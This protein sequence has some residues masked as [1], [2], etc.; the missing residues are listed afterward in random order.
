MT[1]VW[2][3]SNR[4]VLLLALVP[5]AMLGLVAIAAMNLGLGPVVGTAAWILLAVSVL[6]GVGLI[7]QVF[8]PRVAYSRGKVLFYLKSGDPIAVPCEVVEAFF[9]GQGPANLP[10]QVVEKAE[11]VN[12][13]ARLS[14]RAPEWE[15]QDVK[16][17][18]GAWC[19][20]YVTIRGTWCEPLNGEVIRGLNRR[21]AEVCRESQS[22]AKEDP[23]E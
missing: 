20:G 19:D 11:T 16:A 21:L 9:L 6:L 3:H 2:L 5:A 12:L 13:I 8:R 4:R 22:E 15:Q 14:Q 18:L 7:L 23:Q 10:V 1:E 17:A